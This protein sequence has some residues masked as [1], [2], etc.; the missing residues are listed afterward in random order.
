MDN[1]EQ[2]ITMLVSY[3]GDANALVYDAMDAYIEGDL[4]KTYELL[5]E[6][7]KQLNIAHSYQFKM[8][9]TDLNDEDVIISVLLVHAMDIC[10]NA[11]NSIQYTRKLLAV[12]EAKK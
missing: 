2:T 8:L 12:L 11:A 1:Y 9:S 4:E 6:A 3:A 7:D 5:D 10:M